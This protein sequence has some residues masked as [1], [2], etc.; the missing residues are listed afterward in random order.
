MGIFSNLFAKKEAKT[1]EL[2]VVDSQNLLQLINGA[3]KGGKVVTV[4]PRTAISISVVFEC[5]DLITRTLLLVSPKVYEAREKT[6]MVAYG[7][8]LFNLINKQPYTLY[9]AGKFYG[10][11][12]THYLLFGNA[13][14]EILRKGSKVTGLRICE[15]DYVDVDIIELPDGTEEHVYKVYRDN[16]KTNSR[17]IFQS[18]MIHLM[19]YSI[20]GKKGLSRIQIKK[21]TLTNAGNIYNYQ[22]QMYEN[23]INISGIITSD[24]IVDKNA[25][26]YFAQRIN[27]RGKL[28]NG[29]TEVFPAGIKYEQLKYNL[30]FADAQIIEANKFTV[31]DVARMFGVPLSLI[32][33]GESA[34][35]KADREYNTFLTTTIAPICLMIEN[36]FNRKLFPDNSTNYIKFELKGLYRVDMISRYQSYQIALNAGFMNKDEVRYIEDMNPIADGL[37]E[38]YYQQLNTIPL[39]KAEAY[40]DAIIKNGKAKETN[41]DNTGV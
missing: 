38:T 13:Y 8:P 21:N 33:R 40:F 1:T 16:T 17:I 26:E 29:E 39:D 35:N 5:I 18:D 14:V 11:I 25:L 6:K 15:P 7:H 2:R 36:E 20:D 34:D 3:S 23:G 4:S 24:R 28:R 31:E 22:T 32:G 9:D 30:P 12:I 27:E 10:R 37:G 41:N 19:D